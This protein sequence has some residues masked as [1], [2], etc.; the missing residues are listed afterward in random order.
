[1]DSKSLLKVKVNDIMDHNR[2]QIVYIFLLQFFE[3]PQ[4]SFMVLIN[5]ICSVSTIIK[6]VKFMKYLKA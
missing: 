4:E 3:V 1:M 6:A 2:Y 5:I